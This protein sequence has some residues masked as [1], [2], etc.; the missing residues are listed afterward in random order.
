[1]TNDDSDVDNRVPEAASH[2]REVDELGA[3]APVADVHG[4]LARL[5]ELVGR[6]TGG[7]VQAV[8]GQVGAAWRRVTGEEPACRSRSGSSSRSP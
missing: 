5:E 2:E 1:M 3:A 4:L 7:S 8:E 6:P